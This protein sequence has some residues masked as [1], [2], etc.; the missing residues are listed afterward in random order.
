M[1]STQPDHQ[2]VSLCNF[3]HAMPDPMHWY[4]HRQ[5]SA[6]IW[7]LHS[8]KHLWQAGRCQLLGVQEKHVEENGCMSNFVADVLKKYQCE[9]I[10]RAQSV[11]FKLMEVDWQQKPNKKW[12]SWWRSSLCSSLNGQN[13]QPGAHRP[14]S[15]LI[16]VSPP[17]SAAPPTTTPVFSFAVTFAVVTSWGFLGFCVNKAWRE[18]WQWKMN[19]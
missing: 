8:W 1:S 9:W 12:S 3:S 2:N 6:M 19:C 17:P 15:P 5:C 4:L 13:A 7:W 18:E 11:D 14:W 16:V 10:G